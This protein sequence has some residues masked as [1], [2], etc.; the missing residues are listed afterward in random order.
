MRDKNQAYRKAVRSKGVV[1]VLPAEYDPPVLDQEVQEGMRD[2]LLNTSKENPANW[3][4]TDITRQMLATYELQRRDIINA[5]EKV[6]DQMNT[7]EEETD[8]DD[9]PLKALEEIKNLWPFLF[10]APILSLHH[11][12]LTGRELQP[13]L[14]EFIDEK[15][16][17]ALLY[18]TSCS[19]ANTANLSLRLKLEKSETLWNKDNKL[20]CCTTMVANHFKENKSIFLHTVEVNTMSIWVCF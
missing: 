11:K 8:A 5:R 12:R 4:W 3:V 14:Q 19:A 15:L 20:L 10:K 6:L 18:L 9:I 17:V 16:E 13:A 7:D 2:S 1:G